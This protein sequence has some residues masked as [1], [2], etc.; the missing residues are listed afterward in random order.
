MP[1][2]IKSFINDDPDELA[3]EINT[4]IMQIGG[5]NVDGVQFLTPLN[6]GYNSPAYAAFVTYYIVD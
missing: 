2:L 4:F 1:I 5:E 6:A 3:L